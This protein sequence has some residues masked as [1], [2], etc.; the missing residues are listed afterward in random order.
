[1][2]RLTTYLVSANKHLEAELKKRK[3]GATKDSNSLFNAKGEIQG[4]YP[5]FAASFGAAVLRSGLMPAIFLYGEKSGAGKSKEPLTNLFLA[6]LQPEGAQPSFDSLLD[7][8]LHHRLHDEL[9]LRKQILDVSIAAKLALR[10]Y[11]VAGKNKVAE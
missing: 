8:A 9:R 10:S 3:E 11:P 5:P 7:Y 4:E 2:K 1:M 6:M